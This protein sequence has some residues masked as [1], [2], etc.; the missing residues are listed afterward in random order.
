MKTFVTRALSVAYVYSA[1]VYF[2]VMS[3]LKVKNPNRSYILH[4][5]MIVNKRITT[6]C[7]RLIK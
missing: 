5:N 7:E 3:N 1:A 2:T 6:I 4:D